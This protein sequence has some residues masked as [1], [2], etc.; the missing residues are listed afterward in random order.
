MKTMKRILAL[1]IVLV[2][3]ASMLP[4]SAF[5]NPDITFYTDSVTVAAGSRF[6]LSCDNYSDST[7]FVSDNDDLVYISG[8]DARVMGE[9]TA[10]IT[11][12]DADGDTDRFFCPVPFEFGY[13]HAGGRRRADLCCRRRRR[14]AGC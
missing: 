1:L 11:V 7:T 10:N 14:P 8:S 12:T 4:L 13:D 3:T 9:G 6:K 2:M 5:A